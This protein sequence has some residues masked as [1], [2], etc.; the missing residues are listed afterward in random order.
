VRGDR[1]SPAARALHAGGGGAGTLEAIRILA[2]ELTVPLIGFAGAPFTLACYLVD[3][4]STKDFAAM[5]SL[6]FRRAEF[7][8]RLLEGLTKLVAAWCVAQVRAGAR[9][10]Q[11]FDTWAGLLLRP[12]FVA[13]WRP[14]CREIVHAIRAEGRA[15]DLLRGRTRRSLGASGRRSGRGGDRLADSDRRGAAGARRLDGGAGEPRPR[16]ASFRP[17]TSCGSGPGGAAPLRGGPGHVM[18]L[19]H[20]VL[21]GT[22]PEN[23]AALV[24][25]VREATTA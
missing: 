13:V 16:G 7:A 6:L 20:G 14:V 25:T 19:G 21:P 2:R 18:N 17:R 9:A 4:K 3:G 15:G 22:P 12:D 24:K 1:G 5:R 23:V 8:G 10:I 11:I